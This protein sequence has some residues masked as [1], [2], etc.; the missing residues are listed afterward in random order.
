L[1]ALPEAL[2]FYRRLGFH[3]VMRDPITSSQQMSLS[4]VQDF[5]IL[6]QQL[7]F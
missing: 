7:D 5:G 6:E 1:I 4:G 3:S 2:P